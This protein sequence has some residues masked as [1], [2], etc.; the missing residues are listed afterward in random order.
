MPSADNEEAR[1]HGCRC[2]RCKGVIRPSLLCAPTVPSLRAESYA[3]TVVFNS[4]HRASYTVSREAFV[5]LPLIERLILR[6][7]CCSFDAS[8][9]LPS[10]LITVCSPYGLD[11]YDGTGYHVLMGPKGLHYDLS[12]AQ[13][14]NAA[15][16][17]LRVRRG[18]CQIAA[19]HRLQCDSADF[20]R[21]TSDHRD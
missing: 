16:T 6:E 2:G 20:V 13:F 5:S 1:C 17:T 7:I 4:S 19:P 9:S 21:T 12:N 10:A 14:P 3:L 11:W 8:M 18:R 15:P